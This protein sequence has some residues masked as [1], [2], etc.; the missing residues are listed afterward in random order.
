MSRPRKTRF[1]NYLLE[2]FKLGKTINQLYREIN[3]AAKLSAEG[4]VQKKNIIA[5]NTIAA[6]YNEWKREGKPGLLT[7]VDKV[8]LEDG[9][10]MLIYKDKDNNRYSGQE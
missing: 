3:D 2:Q 9:T 10:V 1:D 7:L 4:T 5:Y 8:R 6:R